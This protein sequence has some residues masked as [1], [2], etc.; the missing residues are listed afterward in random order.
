M[1]VFSGL[2]LEVFNKKK[3]IKKS[4]FKL[5]KCQ[6]MKFNLVLEIEEN[7][8]GKIFIYFSLFAFFYILRRE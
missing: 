5:F 1:A 4:I 6:T 2:K 3:S 8:D 7:P